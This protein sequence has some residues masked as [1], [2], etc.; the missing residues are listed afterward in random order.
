MCSHFLT[1]MENY[2]GDLS[3]VVRA[4]T[5]ATDGGST[6]A[7]LAAAPV[8]WQFSRNTVNYSS[9]PADE[10]F[11]DP[12]SYI[13]DPHPLMQ[14]APLSQL[15]Y[16]GGGAGDAGINGGGGVNPGHG[17]FD[18]EMKRPAAN[19]FSRMLQISPTPK[20]PCD[21]HAAAPP[22]RGLKG[23]SLLVSNNGSLISPSS[24]GL[25]ISSPRN[26]GIKRRWDHLSLILINFSQITCPN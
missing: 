6:A 11:G 10:D 20:L 23:P 22:Q 2:Q 7:E 4:T 13:R 15:F 1:M 16:G 26:T 25:Q 8:S 12:F 18:D 5:A 3:D 17:V 19:I 21:F 9:D 14:N 24:S